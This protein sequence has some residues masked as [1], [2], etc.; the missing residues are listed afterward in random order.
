MVSMYIH[1][2]NSRTSVSEKFI[3]LQELVKFRVLMKNF[4]LHNERLAVK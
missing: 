4:K 1:F 3:I 2:H